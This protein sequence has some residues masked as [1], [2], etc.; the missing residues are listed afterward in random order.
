MRPGE[1]K[2]GR[3]EAEEMLQENKDKVAAEVRRFTFLSLSCLF[4]AFMV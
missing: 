2:C 3:N 4:A 1:M